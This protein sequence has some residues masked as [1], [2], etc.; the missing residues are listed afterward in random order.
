MNLHFAFW[1][2]GMVA[3]LVGGLAVLRVRR[4]LRP[5]PVVALVISG[6]ALWF[7]AKVQYRLESLPVAAAVAMPP[8]AL[9]EPGLRLP[10]GLLLA[11][12]SMGLTCVAL[13]APWRE[14]GDAWAMAAS[15]FIVVGRFGCIASGC[16]MGA[17]CAAWPHALCMR[18]GPGT[19][20]YHHQLSQALIA[21]T[22]ISSLPVH[23]LAAYF[24][25]ASFMTV[26]LLA[27]LLRRGS[28]PGTCLAVFC[29]VRPLTK[30][31]L[32]PLRDVARP[33]V[34][35]VGIPASVLVTTLLLLA[36]GL[37]FRRQWGSPGR[38]AD[39]EPGRAPTLMVLE[40]G[41]S[42]RPPVA[43]DIDGHSA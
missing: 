25:L 18:F 38:H 5:A 21:P 36:G 4:T 15:C 30:L 40:G 3:G 22:Q 42:R 20:V 12:L 14:T 37:L 2:L 31:A 33:P 34:L 10:L 32:E 26:G 29:V 9:V 28:T 19:E 11:G 6:F 23:P 24:A 17:V 39:G 27:V 1:A 13:R 35:M 8:S 16:C 43:S 41:V 7:G